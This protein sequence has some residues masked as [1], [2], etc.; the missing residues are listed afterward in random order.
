[1]TNQSS[2]TY[3]LHSAFPYW[4]LTDEQRNELWDDGVHP[5]NIG[6]DVIGSLLADRLKD[7]ISESERFKQLTPAQEPLRNELK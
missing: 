4:N 1:M 5:N 2:Y 7:L 3:D 6:Y